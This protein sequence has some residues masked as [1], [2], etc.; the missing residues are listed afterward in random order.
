M[1]KLIGLVLVCFTAIVFAY[2]PPADKL[3]V[4]NDAIARMTTMIVGGG[5]PAPGGAP[6]YEDPLNDYTCVEAGGTCNSAGSGNDIDTTD[7]R[8]TGTAI[9]R[10]ESS[11]VRKDH[12]STF[13][14]DFEIQ[15]E[16]YLTS[17]DGSSIL[18]IAAVTDVDGQYEAME[19]AADGGLVAMLYGSQAYLVDAG[20]GDW[21][22]DN[23]A[24]STGTQY[25][26]TFFRTTNTVYWNIYSDSGR[27][28]LVTDCDLSVAITRAG[29]SS[30]WDYLYLL[31]SKSDSDGD[32]GTFWSQNYEIV[33]Y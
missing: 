28:S 25:Y 14:G 17:V 18:P 3:P 22:T 32:N 26:S 1:R 4:V 11:Y 5:A 21:T 16:F 30:D 9:A 24:I 33:S 31:V 13:T 10:N 7:V 2:T 20:D 8:V 6:T 23:C 27:E 29:T 15:F 12:V 19:G